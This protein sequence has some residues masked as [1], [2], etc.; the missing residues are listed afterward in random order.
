MRGY[1]PPADA[2]TARPRRCSSASGRRS[3]TRTGHV[4]WAGRL[5]A[6]GVS[7]I[8]YGAR[9][10][11][12]YGVWGT[13]LFQWRH[14]GAGRVLRSLP[15]MP[16]WYLLLLLLAQISALGFVWH[17]FLAALPFLVLGIVALVYQACT[18]AA[19]AHFPAADGRP[20]GRLR[21]RA[22][23]GFLY[24]AQPVARLGGRLRNGLTLWRRRNSELVLPT[25]I[26]AEVF[27]LGAIWRPLLFAFPLLAVSFVAVVHQSRV[28]KLARADVADGV[29][30]VASK[31]G[32]FVARLRAALKPLP[33]GRKYGKVLPMPRTLA[34]WDE[35]W[36][37]TSDR[38]QGVEAGL[39][40]TGTV[41]RHGGGF[42]RW[43]LEVRGGMFGGARMRSAI[44]EHGGGRQLVR[45]R[46]WPRASHFAQLSLLLCISAL[47]WAVALG[48]TALT[49]V[50]AAVVLVVLLRVLLETSSAVAAFL[51]ALRHPPRAETGNESA[52]PAEPKAILRL[53]PNEPD[54]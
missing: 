36:R 9:S 22:L 47:C 35:E 6:K 45:F 50:F 10:S 42:D 21:L 24:L 1:L 16:E 44:E 30:P 17:P 2:A 49:A 54:A 28:G 40:A 46:V 25:L 43:D 7:N 12:Y 31:W 5:Y 8:L 27:V 41:Y 11:I 34:L 48:H 51:P 20:L 4:T 53:V 37:S 23:T 18:G 38:L 29:A 19:H 14:G 32:R 15:L 33:P 13:G 26:L 3:T 52:A 39:Q